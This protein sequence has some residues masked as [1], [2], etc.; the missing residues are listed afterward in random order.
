V[1]I[2]CNHDLSHGL[3]FRDRVETT[4]HGSILDLPEIG[5]ILL[6]LQGLGSYTYIGSS[7]QRLSRYVDPVGGA[8]V[9]DKLPSGTHTTST[10]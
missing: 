5:K 9:S 7:T 3:D 4:I 6:F 10:N 2:V 8:M 1:A